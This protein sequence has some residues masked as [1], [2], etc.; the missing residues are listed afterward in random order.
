MGFLVRD[1][2]WGRSLFLT[3]QCPEQDLELDH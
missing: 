3:D 1:E 2:L